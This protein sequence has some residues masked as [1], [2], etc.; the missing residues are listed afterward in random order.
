MVFRKSHKV[1]DE[2]WGTRGVSIHSQLR[3]L[4]LK[5]DGPEMK[6]KQ[7]VRLS[8]YYTRPSDTLFLMGLCFVT[9]IT[10]LLGYKE[11]PAVDSLVPDWGF[12]LWAITLA[13]GSGLA[14]LGLYWEYPTGLHIELAGRWM[15]WPSCL[16]YGIASYAYDQR[17]LNTFLLL[18]F[19]FTCIRR[20]RAIRERVR[21]WEEVVK[22]YERSD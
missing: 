11:S 6:R 9:A 7:Q 21:E 4:Y 13:A 12:A 1:E 22:A 14:L 16:A 3:Y 15:L 2:L 5:E 17:P 20:I 8:K 10:Q 19:G 18:A